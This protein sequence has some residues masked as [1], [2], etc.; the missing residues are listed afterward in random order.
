MT[1]HAPVGKRAGSL[2]GRVGNAPGSGLAPVDRRIFVVAAAAFAG[3]M[4]LSARYG[5]HRDELYFLDCARHLSLSYVDQ[6]IFAPLVAR[7]SLDLFGVSLTGLRLWP[8]LAAAGTVVTGGLLAREFGGGGMAQ[9]AGALGVA[10]APALLGADHILDTTCFDLLA[11]S[12]LA[13]IVARI[14]R[15]GNTRLWMVAGVILGIGLT[16]KHSIGIFAL[17]IVIG[18]LLSGGRPVL[19][20]RHFA[21]GVLIAVL[22]TIPDL[23]WQAHHG[24]ATVAMTRSLA[25]HNGG[26]ANTLTFIVSQLFMA[27]PVL[28]GVWIAGLRF[29]WRSGRPLWRALAWSYGLLIVF[30]AATS[31]AKPY[32]VAATYFFLLA[33]GAVALEQRW[34]EAPGRAR[35]LFIWL[36]VC[37]LVT[38]PLALPVLPANLAGWTSAVNPVQTETIGWPEFARTVDHVWYQLPAAQRANAVIVTGNYGEAGAI[39]ELGRSDHLPEAVSGQNSV[40]WWG[41]GNPRSTTIVA[42]V[43]QGYTQLAAML[44][45]DFTHVQTIATIGNPA[46]VTNQEQGAHIYLCTGP[47]QPWAQLWPSLRHYN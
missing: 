38:L 31:G 18:A 34:A 26:L 2:L 14:G 41:P 16:N 27:A 1:G 44:R 17:A 24:W 39:N 23:W 29:L 33:S 3:L 32:Y 7:L 9:L 13:L 21:L 28:I 6:P 19:A 42:V 35:T 36:G 8:S 40:W 4:A 5:F 37:V 45:R 46:H 10:T 20:N 22:F 12:V 25:Q 43:Q 15:T 47:V 11:W 30:F